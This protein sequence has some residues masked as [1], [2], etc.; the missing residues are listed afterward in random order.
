MLLSKGACI[1]TQT[2]ASTSSVFDDDDCVY[3]SYPYNIKTFMFVNQPIRL[4]GDKFARRPRWTRIRTQHLQLVRTAFHQKAMLSSCH[5]S[6]L[7]V[8]YLALPP[9]VL[10]TYIMT[11]EGGFWWKCSP[12]KYLPCPAALFNT[13]ACNKPLLLPNLSSIP[14]QTHQYTIL[15]MELCNVSTALRSIMP[16]SGASDSMQRHE[17]L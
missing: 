5:P 14:R 1:D 10:P 12:C 13:S 15:S 11:P 8:T 9:A 4:S 2:S 7:L 16:T 6:C 3:V 17:S